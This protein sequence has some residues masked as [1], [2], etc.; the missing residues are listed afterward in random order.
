[1]AIRMRTNK[2]ENAPEPIKTE[3][4]VKIQQIPAKLDYQPQPSDNPNPVLNEK[5]EFEEGRNYFF[6]DDFN[7]K[8]KYNFDKSKKKLTYAYFQMM[9]RAVEGR[10]KKI[11]ESVQNHSMKAIFSKWTRVVEIKKDLAEYCRI[12]QIGKWINRDWL[13][14]AEV[15][16]EIIHDAKPT[17]I[18]ARQARILNVNVNVFLFIFKI[19]PF[20]KNLLF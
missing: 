10:L 5:R 4:S 8:P 14:P 17:P 18:N 6:N 11:Y 3:G 16:A 2:D 19:I 20:L 15:P 1:M 7:E 12:H 9:S 13:K